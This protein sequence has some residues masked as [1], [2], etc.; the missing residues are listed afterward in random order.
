MKK[1]IL[2]GTAIGDIAGSRFEINNCKTGK[3]FI[4]LHDDFCRFTDDTV[5]TFAVAKALMS[6]KKDLSNLK[7]VIIDNMVEVGRKYP[8]CGYGPSFYFWLKYDEHE[9]YGSYGNG[10][11]MR[12][13]PVSVAINNI[14]KIKEASAIITNVSHN[15]K[16]SIKGA[17][18]VCIAINMALNNKNKDEII[19]YIEKNYFKIHE[20]NKNLKSI[21]EIHINCVETVKQAM[22]AFEESINFEDAIRCAIALGGDSDTIGAITGG[23]AAAYYGVPDNLYNQAKKFLDEYLLKIHDDFYKYFDNK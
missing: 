1:D 5:M 15:H 7:E 14:D 11:A 6:C 10:A 18:A 4:L 22:I 21:K 17:E 8:N 3:E 2:L 13:S 12:I 16:D 20:V 19:E 23:I 9:P